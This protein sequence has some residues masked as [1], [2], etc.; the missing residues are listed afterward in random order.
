MAGSLTGAGYREEPGFSFSFFKYQYSPSVQVCGFYSQNA[1]SRC[2]VLMTMGRW[3]CCRFS[4]FGFVYVSETSG[5]L[6]L[7]DGNL[8]QILQQVL[9]RTPSFNSLELT[10]QFWME[11]FV[12]SAGT[13]SERDC[14]TLTVDRWCDSRESLER[15]CVMIKFSPELKHQNSKRHSFF[16]TAFSEFSRR[17]SSSH[18]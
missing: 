7:V 4:W 6:R 11:L 18:L 1:R 12:G 13:S 16:K 17:N 14:G 9:Q 2:L 3:R 5:T 15:N 10:T 8:L